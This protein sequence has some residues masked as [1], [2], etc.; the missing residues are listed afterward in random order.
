MFYLMNFYRLDTIAK[1][2]QYK[3]HSIIASLDSVQNTFNLF[4]CD[5]LDFLILSTDDHHLDIVSA[6]FLLHRLLQRMKGQFLCIF[7]R[8]FLN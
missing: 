4:S 6:N 2:I 7:K 5:S 8:H 3:I 1:Y